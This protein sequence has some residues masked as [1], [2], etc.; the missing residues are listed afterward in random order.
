MKT[1]TDKNGKTIAKGTV[2]HFKDGW[3]RV[4]S[5]NKTR[6]TVNVGGIFSGRV[7]EKDVPLYEVYEDDAAWFESWQKS[8]TYQSM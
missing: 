1:L 4:T 7:Y 6:Q 3:V 5:V 2:V 8:E